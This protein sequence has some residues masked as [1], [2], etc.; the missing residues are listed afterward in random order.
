MLTNCRFGLAK[1]QS[2]RR[3]LSS[4]FVFPKYSHDNLGLIQSPGNVYHGGAMTRGTI[5]GRQESRDRRPMSS[6][7][8][9]NLFRQMAVKAKKER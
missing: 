3:P 9:N 2:P 7:S 4:Q 6:T 8:K 1:S 5:F